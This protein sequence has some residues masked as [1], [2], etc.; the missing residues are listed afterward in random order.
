MT[1]TRERVRALNDEL[2]RFHCGGRVVLT[3][4]VQA[5][6][7][8]LLQK[9]DEAVISF[10]AFDQGN[11]PYGDHDFG[12]VTVAGHIVFFTIDYFDL[13]LLNHSPDPSDPN[14]TRRIMTIMLAEEH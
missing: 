3:R 14:V 8:D 13:D 7:A 12:A 6:G 4:S 2:R 5:L 10:T 9:I 11:D 1:S